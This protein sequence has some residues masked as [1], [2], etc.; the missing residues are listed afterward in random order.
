MNEENTR[1]IVAAAPP[2]Q[3]HRYL[4][5]SL[6][7]PSAKTEAEFSCQANHGAVTQQAVLEENPHIKFFNGQRG[8]VLCRLT[9]E[10]WHTDYPVLPYVT[11]PGAPIYTRA[12]F[13]VEA[14]KPGL[15]QVGE[16]AVPTRASS[17]IESDSE[18]IRAQK[19]ADGRQLGGRRR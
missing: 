11:A 13:A 6:L 9:P 16:T 7:V 18:R 12:S 14:G 4:H 10:L 15:Q 17:L 3:I 2:S 5:Y 19:R 8:Y 1:S